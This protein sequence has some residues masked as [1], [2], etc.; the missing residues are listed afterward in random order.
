MFRMFRAEDECQRNFYVRLS[1]CPRFQGRLDGNPRPALLVPLPV[2]AGY[3][4]SREETPWSMRRIPTSIPGLP[5]L[6]QLEPPV[7]SSSTAAKF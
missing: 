2:A 7:L 4:G 5:R 3:R 1:E 6:L